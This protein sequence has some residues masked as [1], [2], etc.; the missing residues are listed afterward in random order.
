MRRLLALTVLLGCAPAPEASADPTPTPAPSAPVDAPEPK[1]NPEREPG[2]FEGRT[3]A[4]TMSYLGASWLTRDNRDDEE[5]TT[6]LH[7][8]LALAP[9]QSA[10]DLGAG[11]GYHSLLMA[12]AVG[13]SGQVIASD[14]QPQMLERLQ[15]RAD[16][17][18]ITNVRTVLAKPGDPAL[19]PN[20]CDLI[21]LVDVYHEL[22]DPE[23]V[24]AA[25]RAALTEDGRIALV[26]YREE[27]PDVPIKPLHKMSKA[28]ILREYL[29][30]G[31]AL[32]SQFDGLPWQH[33]MFFTASD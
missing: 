24:L 3:L 31:F 19:P 8:Q 32:D 12:A 33:L 22:A 5:N 26:E 1:P 6:L 20:T 10:C 28:Q 2:T 9:G 7:E 18:G 11:N 15:A 13:E 27:D 14:L 4:Q 25:M 17:A 23:R 16:A 21:L 29:P 30:R